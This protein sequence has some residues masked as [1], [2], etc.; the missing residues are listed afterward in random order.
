MLYYH[1]DEL[2]QMLANI[3]I[4]FWPASLQR[5]HLNL[6]IKSY[7]KKALYFMIFLGS[8]GLMFSIGFLI[9]PLVNPTARDIPYNSIYPFDWKI[10]PIYE[11]VYL[12]H[13]VL[14]FYIVNL[15]VLGF[16]LLFMSI[17]FNIT[18]QYM[19]LGDI[20]QDLGQFKDYKTRKLLDITMNNT[21]DIINND[22]CKERRFL[23]FCIRQHQLLS[24]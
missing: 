4:N 12:G 18:E 24:R 11:I 1:S 5:E 6:S 7:Y 10:S 2:K 23:V 15:A 20:L 3:N 8:C 13:C 21:T 17:C 16:D 19:M 14:N 22:C 9:S